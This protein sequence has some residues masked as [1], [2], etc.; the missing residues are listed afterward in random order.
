[1]LVAIA[2]ILV[3]AIGLVSANTA[4]ETKTASPQSPL[5]AYVLRAG[6]SL[7]FDDGV[8]ADNESLA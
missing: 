2:A 4:R 8:D 6:R 3:S 5:S 7:R 1:M